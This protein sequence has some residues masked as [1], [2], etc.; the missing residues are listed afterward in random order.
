VLLAA[1]HK[2][3]TVLKIHQASFI[4]FEVLLVV[5]VLAY[6]T[7]VMRSVRTDGARAPPR[8]AG[9]GARAISSPPRARRRRS[10]ALS[11]VPRSTPTTDLSPRPRAV[12][13]I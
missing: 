13:R 4:A 10:L 1:G 5:H 9:T 8:R 12:A 2:S 6:A 3:D 7:R 11:L